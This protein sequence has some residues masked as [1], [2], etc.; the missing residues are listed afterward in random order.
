MLSISQI[1]SILSVR[2]VSTVGLATLIL[3]VYSIKYLDDYHQWLEIEV[4]GGPPPNRIGYMASCFLTLLFRRDKRNPKSLKSDEAGG[5]LNA[6]DLPTRSSSPPK[7]AH[8]VIPHR[9]VTQ[10]AFDLDKDNTEASNV[11]SFFSELIK[12]HNDCFTGPSRVEKNIKALFFKTATAKN[13][14]IHRHVKDGSF[15]VKLHC[16]DAKIVLEKKWGELF[17]TTLKLFTNCTPIDEIVL[18]YAP[19]SEKDYPIYK[20]IVEAALKH[21]ESLS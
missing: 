6:K 14:V 19:Q 2:S 4:P 9:Q 17:P 8:W 12:K 15:H 7:M 10:I 3:G 18:L 11:D 1:A 21:Y 16:Q 20:I 13:E 5:Y